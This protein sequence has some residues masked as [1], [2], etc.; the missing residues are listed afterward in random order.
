MPFFALPFPMIDPVAVNI[1][2]LPL[3][4]YALA[5]IAGFI[6]GWQGL[7]LMIANASLWTSGQPRPT[8]EALDDLLVYVAFGVI[9]GGRLGHVLIYDP[10]FYLAH[11]LEILKTWK[12]GM[13]FHGG[14]IG[15]ATSMW[16][17]ARKT[18]M[19]LLTI[20]DLCAVVGPIGIFF[21][22]LAN[23]IKP[24]MW[25]RES[26]VPWAMVFP[27]AGD[28]PRHPSQLYEAGL[29]GLA[30]G[31]LLWLAARSGALKQ[32]G[33]VTGLFSIGYGFARIFC[34]FFREPDPVQEALPN[35]LTMG[36]AL[37]APLILVGAALVLLSL[38]RRSVLA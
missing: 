15:A 13:A 23:F 10:A 27:G 18:S 37:S 8:L 22:R 11:P 19:P 20:T 7:R 38:R 16:L 6:V 4:W 5:Y 29:E 12:G 32:P 28:M 30:L 31:A 26:D 25:G 33:L 17:F 2:P 36:M 24:E 9:I 35:G 34:E 3:R 14:L 1:G 21:G